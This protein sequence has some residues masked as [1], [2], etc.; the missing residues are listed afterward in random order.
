MHSAMRAGRQL[1]F[2][3]VASGCNDGPQR[4]LVTRVTVLDEPCVVRRARERGAPAVERGTHGQVV[5]AL[6]PVDGVGGLPRERHAEAAGAAFHVAP[7]VAHL[8]RLADERRVLLLAHQRAYAERP[9]HELDFAL[10]RERCRAPDRQMAVRAAD[11]EV[12]VEGGRHGRPQHAPAVC[13]WQARG[14]L[15]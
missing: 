3:V 1:G 11:E 2:V 4:G 9:P 8:R 14:G 10:A 15:G 5:G 13:C 7:H 12:E 6:V